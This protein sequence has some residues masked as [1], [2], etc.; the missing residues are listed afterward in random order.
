MDAC[1]NMRAVECFE[2]QRWDL[3]VIHSA[4]DTPVNKEGFGHQWFHDLHGIQK[5]SKIADIFHTY[6]TLADI[7]FQC[8]FLRLCTDDIQ[9]RVGD[10]NI[11]S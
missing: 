1:N 2:F 5:G 6:A 4:F 7:R 9:R 8:Q 3:Q 11:I 10:F